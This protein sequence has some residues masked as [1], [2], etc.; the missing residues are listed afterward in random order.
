MSDWTARLK[1]DVVGPLVA[2]SDPAISYLARRDLLGERLLE[3]DALWNLPECKRVVA[4]QRADGAWRYPGGNQK[5]RSQTNYDQLETYRQLGILIYRYELNRQHPA[6]ERAAHFLLSFQTHAG[7]FRGIYGSQFTPNYSAAITELLVKAGYEASPQ[8]GRSMR[9]LLSVRQD[10]GGW[11]LPLR[12]RGRNLDV[13]MMRREP[14]EADRAKPSSHLITGIVLRAFAAHDRWRESDEARAAGELL[15]MRFLRPDRYPDH[16]PASHWLTFSY[17]F[18]WTDLVSAL[19]SLLRLHF[20]SGD[21]DVR[22]GL[23]WFI[24]H[25]GPHGMWQEGR[26]RP[27]GPHADQWVALAVCRILR[28]A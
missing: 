6:I 21:P 12:T 1:R 13:T 2:S 23:E 17:P 16:R 14:L 20:N 25:Q 24:D 10:D 5:I 15:K 26:N 7:D 18:W 4:R 9:W 19:D 22:G 28:N 27:K 3:T 8:V 11:A